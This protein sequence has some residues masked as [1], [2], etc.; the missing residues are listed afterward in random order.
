MILYY[1]NIININDIINIVNLLLFLTYVI[2]G[3]WARIRY[4]IFVVLLI[5]IIMEIIS[6]ECRKEEAE[7]IIMMRRDIFIN[8]MS[9]NQNIFL[10]VIIRK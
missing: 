6:V 8:E 10:K 5:L 2:L 7:K 1:N 9:V 3:T 4:L